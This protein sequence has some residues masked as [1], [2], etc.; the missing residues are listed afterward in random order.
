MYITL[1]LDV[2]HYCACSIAEVIYEAYLLC[3]HYTVAIYSGLVVSSTCIASV[4]KSE[5]YSLFR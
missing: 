5:V 3:I 4:I 1:H 2:F